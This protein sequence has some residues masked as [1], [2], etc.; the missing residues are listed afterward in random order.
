MLFLSRQ[1]AIVF[2]FQIKMTS[3]KNVIKYSNYSFV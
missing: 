3:I 2:C 1:D